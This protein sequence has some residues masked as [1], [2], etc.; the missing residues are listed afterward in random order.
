M[1][2]LADFGGGDPQSFSGLFP[3]KVLIIDEKKQRN[4]YRILSKLCK[5]MLML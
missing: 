3:R 4:Y 2:A 1:K 5:K